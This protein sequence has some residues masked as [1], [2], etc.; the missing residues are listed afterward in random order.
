MTF[1]NI[2]NTMRWENELA[3]VARP[4]FVALVAIRYAD[5]DAYH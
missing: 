1:V 2:R 5:T 4:S 3:L